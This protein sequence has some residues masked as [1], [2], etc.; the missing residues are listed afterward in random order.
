MSMSETFEV[1]A[2]EL[3]RLRDYYAQYDVDLDL[4]D[5]NDEERPRFVRLNPRFNQAETLAMVKVCVSVA[6]SKERPKPIKSGTPSSLFACC[7]FVLSS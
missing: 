7:G 1:A 5:Q 4:L 2:A 3:E 6:C